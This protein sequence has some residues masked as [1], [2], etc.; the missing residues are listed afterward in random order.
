MRRH[1]LVPLTVVALAFA[2]S[3]TAFAYPSDDQPAAVGR[4]DLLGLI[5]DDDVFSTADLTVLLAPVVPMAGTSKGTQHYGPYTTDDTDSGC[6]IN[7]WN[8]ET[9]DRHFTVRDNR[10]GTFT[11]VEQ[12]KKGDFLTVGSQSPG[13]Q[14]PENNDPLGVSYLD[15]GITGSMHGYFIITNV[16]GPQTSY[17]SH[18]NGLT[19]TTDATC[20]T[21]QFIDTHF[22]PCYGAGICT[23]PTYFFHYAAGDQG[24]IEHEWTNASAD[25]GGNR[26]DI[27]TFDPD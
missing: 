2:T 23:V 14:C 16:T 8:T 7:P 5:G 18:C 10:D 27:A 12:F 20:N 17:D 4:P 15:A 25:R 1:L 3:G 6:N 13:E 26:G 9:F 22:T 19:G 21:T 24:L 11:V